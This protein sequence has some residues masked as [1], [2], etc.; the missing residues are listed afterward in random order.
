MALFKYFK[1]KGESSAHKNLPDE[2]GPLCREVSASSIRE[3]NLEV[4]AATEKCEGKRSSRHVA[5]NLS[6]LHYT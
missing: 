3:A 4:L 1:R 2:N 6:S 5:Y